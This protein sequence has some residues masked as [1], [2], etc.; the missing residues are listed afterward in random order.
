MLGERKKNHMRAIVENKVRMNTHK[1]FCT[2][3][4]KNKQTNKQTKHYQDKNMLA[5]GMV[6]LYKSM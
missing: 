5:K 1:Y 3:V 2:Y 4:A 6:T